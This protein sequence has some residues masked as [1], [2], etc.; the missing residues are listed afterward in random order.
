MGTTITI[1]ADKP[2]R[3]A[4][5]RKARAEKRTVSEVV[6]QIL[7]DALVQRPLAE[8]VGRT[9]GSLRMA[10]AHAPW[11]RHIRERNWRP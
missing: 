8:R 6:R 1:R 5:I 3:D 9:R 4:L 7:E 10:E 11:Q 2:L